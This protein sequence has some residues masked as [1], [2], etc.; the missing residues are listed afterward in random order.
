M[1]RLGVFYHFHAFLQLVTRDMIKK[2]KAFLQREAIW[3]VSAQGQVTEKLYLCHYALG[4]NNTHFRIWRG[5]WA[6]EGVNSLGR[7]AEETLNQMFQVAWTL[8][9]RAE[10]DAHLGD[11]YVHTYHWFWRPQGSAYMSV[12]RDTHLTYCAHSNA[13]HKAMQY[14]KRKGNIVVTMQKFFVY[15]LPL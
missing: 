14:W 2:V 1:S 10:E 11:V 9:L 15:R 3:R 7:K 6:E 13:C 5:K 8:L 12:Y 4:K